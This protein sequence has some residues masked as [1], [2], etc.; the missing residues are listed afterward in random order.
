MDTTYCAYEE[1]T[2]RLMADDIANGYMHCSIEC[3]ELDTFAS[4]GDVDD[5]Y[6]GE[7]DEHESAED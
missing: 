6:R 5:G 4:W 7:P 3:Y 1:C 2:N